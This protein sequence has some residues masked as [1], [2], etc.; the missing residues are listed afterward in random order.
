MNVTRLPY[1]AHGL[2]LAFCNK[3]VVE[4]RM[5]SEEYLE[6]I[7]SETNVEAAIAKGLSELDARDACRKIFEPLFVDGSKEVAFNSVLAVARK[8]VNHASAAQ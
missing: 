1:T 4:I 8:D 7:M 6:Y 3:F 2:S 5:S